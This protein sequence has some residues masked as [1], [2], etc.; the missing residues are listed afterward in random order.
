MRNERGY[1]LIEMTVAVGLFSLVMLLATG[2][3]LKFISLD[4]RA[5]STSEVANNLTFAVDSM[6][7]SIR[8]GQNYRCG[9]EGQGPNCWSTQT[10]R[11][12]FSVLDDDGRTVTYLLKTDG[13]IGR[14]TTTTGASCTSANAT[15]LTDPRITIQGLSFYV[16]GV[17]TTTAAEKFVQPHVLF[18]IHGY[19]RPE[20]DG[21]T[22]D[23]TIETMATQRLIE[24]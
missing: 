18:T 22:L 15:S 16:R 11:S 19:M 5:R 21:P 4:K 24:L 1:T 10:S 14:C 3:F 13:S 2:A 8:T 9:G 12:T 17:G 7:R 20:A 23:F 6:A